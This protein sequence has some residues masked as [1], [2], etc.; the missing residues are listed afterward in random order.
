MIAYKK[1]SMLINNVYEKKTKPLSKC[2]QILLEFSQ[3]ILKIQISF[4]Q[5]VTDILTYVGPLHDV[6]IVHVFY[7]DFG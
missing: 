4:L 3:R 5:I 1:K 2:E 7:F 6:H